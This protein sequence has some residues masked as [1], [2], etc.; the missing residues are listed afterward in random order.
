MKSPGYRIN[1]GCFFARSRCTSLWRRASGIQE[2]V[3]REI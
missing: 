2:A 1:K 3:A